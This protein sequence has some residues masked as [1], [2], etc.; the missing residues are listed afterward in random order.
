[1]QK[2]KRKLNIKALNAK[3]PPKTLKNKEADTYCYSFGNKTA[4]LRIGK[5]NIL[6]E[7]DIKEAVFYYRCFD[8]NKDFDSDLQACPECAKPLAKINL[9]KCPKC[10]AKNDPA[11]GACWVCNVPLP[12]PQIKPDREITDV[13][14]LEMNG[15]VYRSTDKFLSDDIKRLFA[16]LAANGFDKKAFESWVKG[17]ELR[18]ETT[19]SLVKDEVVYLKHKRKNRVAFEMAVGIIFTATLLL[20]IWV[21]QAK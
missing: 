15:K 19:I 5:V 7:S 2:E 3:E 16:G 21:F 12:M 9:K 20:L 10:S 1:M 13:L 6:K 18:S 4:K 8:C 11:R 14:V 17:K